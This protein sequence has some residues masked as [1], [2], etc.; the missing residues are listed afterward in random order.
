MKKVL[1]IFPILCILIFTSCINE[2]GNK[3]FNHITSAGNIQNGGYVIKYLDNYIYA[4]EN[5]YNNLYKMNIYE[6]TEKKISGNQFFY[7]INLYNNE[8]YYVSSSPGEVWK[9]SMDGSSKKRLIKQKV[10]NLL[11]Y[12][13]HMYYRL[14][15]DNDWGKLYRADLTGKNKCL[16][17]QKVKNFCIYDGLIYY[18][19]VSDKGTICSMNTDGTE[20]TIINNAYA[21]NILVENNLLI[22]SDHNRNDKLYIYDLKNNIE[23]C[24]SEDKC[25]DLN[26]NQELIFFRNQ[27]DSGKLY[28]ITFDGS[29]KQKIVDKNVTD[30]LVIDNLILY[31]NV[32]NENKIEYFNLDNLTQGNV[33]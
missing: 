7:E 5:D 20:I 11:L 27:S 9:I 17:A 19:N 23:T 2:N 3:A 28:S 8:L 14:S 4:N 22:Y 21:N 32:N 29:I 13:N 26:C 24:I 6:K 15:E 30:I 18:S 12:D 31:K 10:G 16:L 25:W 33:S 1:S